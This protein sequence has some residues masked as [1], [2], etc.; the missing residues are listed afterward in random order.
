MFKKKNYINNTIL[1]SVFNFVMI[2]NK[3]KEY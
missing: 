1:I 2:R 3:F